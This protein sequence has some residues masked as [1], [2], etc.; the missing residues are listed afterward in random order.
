MWRYTD[1]CCTAT[2]VNKWFDLLSESL[3]IDVIA[4][5]D[6]AAFLTA[7]K[8]FCKIE[9]QDWYSYRTNRN[10]RRCL[11]KRREFLSHVIQTNM[12]D[13]RPNITTTK[14]SGT[15][16]VYFSTNRNR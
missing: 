15:H 2:A 8:Q 13:L 11:D 14:P 6:Q 10:R 4:N 12:F 3:W 1:W 9:S 5:H 16:D 7:E